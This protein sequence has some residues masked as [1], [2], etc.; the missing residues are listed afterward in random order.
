MK[1]EH[2]QYLG[3]KRRACARKPVKGRLRAVRS[4]PCTECASLSILIGTPCRVEAALTGSG[5][6]AGR[7]MQT[8]Q[9]I[10]DQI[11]DAYSGSRRAHTHESETAAGC[12]QRDWGEREKSL[13]S[14]FALSLSQLRGIP[15]GVP[16]GR[17]GALASS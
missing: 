11:G 2:R 8:L 3:A 4:S 5:A 1:F 10:P 15:H 17:R 13:I 12:D 9:A 16:W 14:S 7:R 6:P